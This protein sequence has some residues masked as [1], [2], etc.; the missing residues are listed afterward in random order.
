MRAVVA[1]DRH[2]QGVVLGQEGDREDLLHLAAE[3]VERDL[4]PGDVGDDQVEEPG[5]EV[6]PRGLGEQRRR[7]E[8]VEARDHFGAER[9]LGALQPLHLLA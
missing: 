7:R 3:H 6:D 9:L 2:R 5:R 4:R 8:V 1:H